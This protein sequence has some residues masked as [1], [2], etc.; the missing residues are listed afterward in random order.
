MRGLNRAFAVMIYTTGFF[1]CT[2]PIEGGRKKVVLGFFFHTLKR[3]A[4][5][6]QS[7]MK[8][9]RFRYGGHLFYASFFCVLSRF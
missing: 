3:M 8:G 7:L 2:L 9:R 4:R 5:V 1:S 6:L